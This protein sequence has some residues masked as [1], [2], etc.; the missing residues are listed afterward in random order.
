M[1]PRRRD[2]VLP[3][4]GEDIPE[5]AVVIADADARNHL[6]IFAECLGGT[7]DSVGGL[8]P[9]SHVYPTSIGGVRCVSDNHCNS[10][11]Y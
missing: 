11:I 1:S 9:S 5:A 8:G 3:F 6:G 7:S 2:H 10:P 4:A